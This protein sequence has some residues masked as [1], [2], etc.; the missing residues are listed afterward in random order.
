M[1]PPVEVRTPRY[2][3]IALVAGTLFLISLGTAEAQ[4]RSNLT[5]TQE[6]RAEVAKCYARCLTSAEPMTQTRIALDALDGEWS[7][8]TFRYVACLN[9]QAAAQRQDACSSGCR[10]IEVAYGVRSSYIRTRYYWHLNRSLRSV[11]AAGLWTAWNRFPNPGSDAF[12]RACARYTQAA[13]SHVETAARKLAEVEPM[14][15][16]E[17][18]ARRQKV[19]ENE[20]RPEPLPFDDFELGED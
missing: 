8:A 2:A 19:I 20:Y 12:I 7:T 17:F 4:Q 3:V 16:S 15:P 18:E 9:D 10:D 1:I 11:R 5:R 14:N 6:G 13:R